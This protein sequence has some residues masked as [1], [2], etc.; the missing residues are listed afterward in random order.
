M[1]G[2]EKLGGLGTMKQAIIS[3]RTGRATAGIQQSLEIVVSSSEDPW[4]R[5]ILK[6]GGW[7]KR[8]G[9]IDMIDR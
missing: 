1:G 4:R 3:Y 7:R 6:A 2:R 5:V 8:G 9:R